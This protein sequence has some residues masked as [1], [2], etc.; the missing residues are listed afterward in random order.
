MKH[1]YVVSYSLSENGIFKN[2]RVF[3]SREKSDKFIWD[4]SME[5]IHYRIEKFR[6]E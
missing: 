3:S 5:D 6:L 4:N 2:S 1:V